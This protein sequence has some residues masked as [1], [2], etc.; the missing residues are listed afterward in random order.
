MSQSIK[1]RLRK[2]NN[3]HNQ[4]IT[5]INININYFVEGK[6]MQLKICI[7]CPCNTFISHLSQS[8][9]NTEDSKVFLYP[10]S[11]VTIS[12][13][14]SN[15]T[16]FAYAPPNPSYV[17][18]LLTSVLLILWAIMVALG[19]TPKTFLLLPCLGGCKQTMHTE[20]LKTL[21]SH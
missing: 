8:R 14:F 4:C 11:P 12:A 16:S 10:P 2:N 15:L 17:R 19:A 1:P 13:C 20:I 9:T 21:L 5:G 6:I 3:K 18:L 7:C